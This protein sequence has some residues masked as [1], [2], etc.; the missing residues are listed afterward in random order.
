MLS[1]VRDTRRL[2]EQ[3]MERCRRAGIA[4]PGV[5]LRDDRGRPRLVEVR[6]RPIERRTAD[7]GSGLLAIQGYATV[8][9]VS[10]PV[11]GGKESGWG[12]DETVVSGAADKSI[13]ER[14][15]VRLLENHEGSA[16]AR[17]KSGTL[18]L[19][20]DATGL[21]VEADLDLEDPQVRSLAVKMRR[22]DMDEMSFAFQATRQEWNESYD[23]R[24][25]TE[26]RLFDVSVVTYPANS[27]TSVEIVDEASGKP[28]GEARSEADDPEEDNP[29]EDDDDEGGEAE[30][31]TGLPL[32]HARVLIDLA[33]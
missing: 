28:V 11:L 27:A 10:Y 30:P 3:V 29:E 7:D 13:A 19:T 20:S 2:P 5:E 15:D 22:G 8:Y 26:I 4:V 1:E 12:W 21:L 17:T 31:R 6:L 16:L 24:F 25:I 9:D 14:D 18:Q 32:A 33:R 23:E